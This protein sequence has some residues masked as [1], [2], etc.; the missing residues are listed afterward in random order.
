MTRPALPPSAAQTIFAGIAAS[1]RQQAWLGDVTTRWP[2][3]IANEVQQ[4]LAMLES[5]L[6]AGGI[7][8]QVR[9]TAEV[10]LKTLMLTAAA[11][12][13]AHGGVDAAA[14][15]RAALFSRQMSLGVWKQGFAGFAT[16]SGAGL[17]APELLTLAD[18]AGDFMATIGAYIEHRNTDIGHGAYR[19]DSI[20]LARRVSTQILGTERQNGFEDGLVDAFATVAA[21]G[22]WKAC[23]MHVDSPNGPRFCGASAIKTLQPHQHG[24]AVERRLFLVRGERA[25]D[26][27]PFVTGRICDE[28]K[29]RDAFLFDSP[30]DWKPTKENPRFDFIDYANGHRL[31]VHA[32]KTDPHLAQLAELP[33]ADLIFEARKS[34][35]GGEF[36]SKDVARLLDDI[37]FDQRFIS[38]AWLRTP[39]RQYML[40]QDR[41]I[42]WLQAPGHVGKTMFVRGLFGEGLKRDEQ[43]RERALLGNDVV[44][45]VAPV[46]LKREYR[47]DAGQFASNLENVVRS[48]LKLDTRIRGLV[49]PDKGAPAD[50]QAGFVDF[51]GRA[52]E[53]AAQGGATRL[54]VAL[55]GLDELRAP[56]GENPVSVLDYIP[57]AEALPAGVTILLTSRPPAECP[58]WMRLR[59]SQNFAPSHHPHAVGAD[60]PHYLDLLRTYVSKNLDLARTEPD[61]EDVFQTILKRSGSLFLIVSFLCDLIRDGAALEAVGT[62]V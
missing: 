35:P 17:M 2:A 18:P 10:L 13:I 51:L 11:D 57:P 4:L 24:P 7:L 37:M 44:L 27:W 12:L 26:L 29:L 54:I 49:I 52:M 19:P 22:V 58:P 16:L 36:A 62:S 55:D 8:M 34:V 15:A 14:A 40:A 5:G 43:R 41:G 60:D 9:D 23:A 47:Y 32:A 3:P 45:N 25:L 21:S 39:L 38:P 48:A 56:E 28:C 31:T 42:F 20:E 50:L 59:L 1:I 33:A 30:K 6:D 53:A 61:F 46:F